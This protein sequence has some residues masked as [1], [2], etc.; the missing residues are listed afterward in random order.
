[1]SLIA[2]FWV[3][4][5]W[6]R[7]SVEVTWIIPADMVLQHYHL[8]APL[9]EL[10]HTQHRVVMVAVMVA[11]MAGDPLTREEVTLRAAMEVT[12]SR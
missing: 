3:H 10:L 11:V 6:W 9:W 4:S 12:M 7:L 2:R 1:M 8:I 5:F